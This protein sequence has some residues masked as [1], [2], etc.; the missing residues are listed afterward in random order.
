[1]LKRM[2]KMKMEFPMDALV[3]R[4][5]LCLVFVVALTSLPLG[6][7]QAKTMYVNN[8]K[9]ESIYYDSDVLVIKLT[10]DALGYGWTGWGADELA[11]HVIYLVERDG[12]S[13]RN[14]RISK[15]AHEIKLHCIAYSGPTG[16]LASIRKH[17]NPVNVTWRELR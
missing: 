1:M 17:A 3:K 6:E 11:R 13:C 12:K 4:A 2:N 16:K 8:G 5:F 7:A 15:L 9:I 10:K 14:V